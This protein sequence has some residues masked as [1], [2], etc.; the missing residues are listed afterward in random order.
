MEYK[1]EKNIPIPKK[2]GVGRKAKDYYPL[3]KMQV[4]DSFLIRFKYTTKERLKIASRISM[5]QKRNG[6]GKKFATRRV[7]EGIRVWR[8]E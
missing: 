7:D 8:K 5:W 2:I 1:I 6:A 4:G 3:E